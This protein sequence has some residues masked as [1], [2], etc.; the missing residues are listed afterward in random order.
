M[1]EAMNYVY[2]VYKAASFSKA[3]QNLYISQPSLSASIK[4]EEDRIGVK[5]FNRNKSPIELTPPGKIYVEH[6]EKI[7]EI[8]EDFQRYID[9]FQ[10]LNRGSLS[11]GANNI[12]TSFLLPQ[13]VK[14]YHQY[15]PNL[16]ITI[17]EGNTSLD[18]REALEKGITDIA[19][20]NFPFEGDLFG[21][22]L[23]FQEKLFLVVP[24]KYAINEAWK[25]YRLNYRDILENKH[26]LKTLPNDK[27]VQFQNLHFVA[28]KKESDNRKRFDII[29]NRYSLVPNIEFELDQ[30]PSAYYI[31][32]SGLGATFSSSTLLRNIRYSDNLCFYN[33]DEP[34]LLR[35][36]YIYTKKNKYLS[37]SILEFFRIASESDVIH[38][39]F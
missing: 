10:N 35:N 30:S 11:I 9:D 19:L 25:E 2:E 14:E 5:I 31:A 29:M 26:P 18:I 37:K 24:K 8:E 38:S 23:L 7:M 27:F 21:K 20:D 22:H 4:R 39:D 17:T 28:L 33:L 6:V 34:E 12:Y 1:F 32:N 16:Q 13:I 15:Y 3:A 36:V